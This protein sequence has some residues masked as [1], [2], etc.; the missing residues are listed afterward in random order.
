MFWW[1]VAWMDE[2]GPTDLSGW[3]E[4]EAERTLFYLDNVKAWIVLEAAFRIPLKRLIE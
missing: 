4:L 2:V 3:W 1:W